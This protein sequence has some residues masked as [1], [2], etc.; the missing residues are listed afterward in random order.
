[1]STTFNPSVE[2]RSSLFHPTFMGKRENYASH[3]ATSRNR[4]L[5]ALTPN[6]CRIFLDRLMAAWRADHVN[7]VTSSW[8]K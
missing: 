4:A 5:R 7:S 6:V 1:M 8:E 3:I 2:S